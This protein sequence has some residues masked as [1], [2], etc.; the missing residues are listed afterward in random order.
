MLDW[1]ILF[2][3]ISGVLQASSILPYIQGML[4]GTTRPNAVSWSL[5]LVLQIIAI[6]GQVS[7]GASWSLVFLFATTFNIVLVLFFSSRGYGYKKYGGIDFV[8]LLAAIAAIVV[9]K[10]TGNPVFAISMAVVADFIALVPTIAKTYK[11]PFSESVASWVLLV[12]AASF[13]ALSTT[14]F[15]IANL[16]YP[17][18]AALSSFSIVVLAYFGQRGKKE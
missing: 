4:K 17:V 7:S 18:Y 9:W 6:S 1:H 15:D 11:E 12:A 2:A 8:C 10:T 14:K 5:W 3:V 16:L 13:A